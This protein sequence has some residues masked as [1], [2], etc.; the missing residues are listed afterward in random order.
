MFLILKYGMGKYIVEIKKNTKKE[1]ILCYEFDEEN[2]ED[3]IKV[4]NSF[5]NDIRY[6]LIYK[7]YSISEEDIINVFLSSENISE[8]MKNKIKLYFNIED[9]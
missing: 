8:K 5:K 6:E 4:I 1:K 7:P 3:I 9:D 2:F